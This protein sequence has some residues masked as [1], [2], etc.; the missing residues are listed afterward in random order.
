MGPAGLMTVNPHWL[1]LSPVVAL[2]L[3]LPYVEIEEM[4]TASSL[5]ITIF[6]PLEPLKLGILLSHP[7]LRTLPRKMVKY[8][9]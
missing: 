1:L 3:Q 4:E 8:T 7:E 6:S 2:G 5:Y 9:L